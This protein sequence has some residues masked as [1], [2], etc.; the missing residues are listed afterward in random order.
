MEISPRDIIL[1]TMETCSYYHEECPESCR[2][3]ALS[4]RIGRE[5]CMASLIEKAIPFVYDSTPDLVGNIMSH[6]KKPITN[7][8][9]QISEDES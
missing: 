7:I 2:R 3:Y 1:R 8:Q 4:K 6:Y 9:I 5:L